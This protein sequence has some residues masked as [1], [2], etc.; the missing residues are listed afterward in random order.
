MDKIFAKII[1]NSNDKGTSI[2][3]QSLIN[4]KFDCEIYFNENKFTNNARLEKDNSII[5]LFNKKYY[6]LLLK[7]KTLNRHIALYL[8][9]C[10]EK[11]RV[12]FTYAR[13]WRPKRMIR[14]KLLLPI[15]DLG[16]PNWDYMENVMRELESK[17][18]SKYIQSKI[19]N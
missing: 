10:I 2:Q 13:K 4:D 19:A 8:I 6:D 12:C 15:D 18:I 17:S 9:G 3:R 11:Q 7:G 1:A 14:S 5:Y 16:N